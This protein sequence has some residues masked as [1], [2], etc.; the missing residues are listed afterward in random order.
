MSKQAF[1]A[2]V[3]ADQ[4]DV[5]AYFN[6]DAVLN[7]EEHLTLDAAIAREMNPLSLDALLELQSRGANVLD[8]RDPADFAA[9]HLAGSIKISVTIELK[10]T[11]AFK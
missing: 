8:T 1:I 10:V 7:S 11:R 5:P 3:T 2:V 9:A 4:P 6:Y